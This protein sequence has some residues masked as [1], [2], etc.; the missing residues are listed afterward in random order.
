MI[1]YENSFARH[2]PLRNR[3][4]F[5]P[6]QIAEMRRRQKTDVPD[7][8]RAALWLTW[9]SFLRGDWSFSQPPKR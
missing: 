3:P 4:I 7:L 8:L 2:S 6:E 9:R 5:T 1:A